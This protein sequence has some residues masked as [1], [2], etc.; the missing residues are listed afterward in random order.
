AVKR[1]LRDSACLEQ[2]AVARDLRIVALLG[3][4]QALGEARTLIH[5]TLMLALCLGGRALLLAQRLERAGL[6]EDLLAQPLT[7]RPQRR[8]RVGELADGETV[9]CDRRRALPPGLHLLAQAGGELLELVAS[10][11]EGGRRAG[12]RARERRS[13]AARAAV[14]R[15]GGRR[16]GRDAHLHE[17]LAPPSEIDEL[18]IEALQARAQLIL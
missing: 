6:G 8:H 9:L 14:G 16:R 10:L 3:G 7:L 13:D 11:V 5:Q 15:R 18:R 4:A 12:W 2:L 17:L 1:L